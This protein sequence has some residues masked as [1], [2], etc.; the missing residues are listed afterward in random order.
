MNTGLSVKEVCLPS[1]QSCTVSF[2][3]PALKEQLTCALGQLTHMRFLANIVALSSTAFY[4]LPLEQAY[5]LTKMWTAD[6]DRKIDGHA[7]RNFAMH[8]FFICLV[9]FPHHGLHDFWQITHQSAATALVGTSGEYIVVTSRLGRGY[10]FDSARQPQMRSCV[11]WR[12]RPQLLRKVKT[13]TIYLK[14]SFCC[15]SP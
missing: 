11:Q 13:R 7:L 1:E 12:C 6:I 10:R 3:Q 5:R 9:V 15:N 8:T 4:T 2:G 14:T